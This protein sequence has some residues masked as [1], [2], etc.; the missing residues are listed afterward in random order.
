MRE[1]TMREHS[2]QGSS[3]GGRFREEAAIFPVA[4]ASSDDSS[5]T[6]LGCMGRAG[7]WSIPKCP[8]A[9]LTVPLS[10]CPPPPQ[11]SQGPG[12]NLPLSILI[13]EGL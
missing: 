9:F 5:P 7:C 4:L 12:G 1:D 2:A 8:Q 10:I 3:V 13:R 6:F 11:R